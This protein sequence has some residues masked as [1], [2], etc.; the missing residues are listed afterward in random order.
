L[1]AGKS[2]DAGISERKLGEKGGEEM[3]QL[4]IEEMPAH[5]HKYTFSSGVN[6]PKSTDTTPGEFGQK[7]LSVDTTPAGGNKPHNNMPPFDVL[8]YCQRQ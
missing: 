5:T 8:L 1:G 3:H 7:D 4:T 6:S 2:S